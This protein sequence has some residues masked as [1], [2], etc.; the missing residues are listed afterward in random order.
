[1]AGR[2]I[3][4]STE[5]MKAE[6]LRIGNLTTR[7]NGIIF[8]IG[9][10]DIEYCDSHPDWFVPIKLEDIWFLRA[11][12]INTLGA[13]CKNHGVWNYQIEKHPTFKAGWTFFIDVDGV[14][15]PPSVQITYVHE[16]QNLWYALTK[17][18]LTFDM[19]YE[20]VK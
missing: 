20:T 8:P 2:R 6:E 16:L 12:F 13:Y 4:K 17:E 11:G 9:V 7:M 10:H 5:E 1:V 3:N 19:Q 15:A 14:A 18:E